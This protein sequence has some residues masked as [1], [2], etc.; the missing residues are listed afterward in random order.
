MYLRI[1]QDSTIEYPYS[2]AK[3]TYDF[4]SVSFPKEKSLELLAEYGVYPVT[5][6]QQPAPTLTQ[7]PV[8]QTPQRI[9]GVWTQVW[10]MVDAS[11]EEAARRQ[12][13]AAKQAEAATVALDAFVQDFIAM[14]PAGVETYVANN[15][16][17]IAA[18][19]SLVS[20]M[21]LMLLILAKNQFR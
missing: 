1:K 17:N 6:V 4:P 15:T 8:E 21:A 3:L 5:A 9:N 19:R 10:A 12:A 18:M 14:T 20:K 7:D 16:P 2:P 13:D 11:A